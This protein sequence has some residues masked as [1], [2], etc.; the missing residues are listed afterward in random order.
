M[1]ALALAAGALDGPAPTATMGDIIDLISYYLAVDVASQSLLQEHESK[2]ARAA[3]GT[4]LAALI[5]NLHAAQ[6]AATACAVARI[7]RVQLLPSRSSLDELSKTWWIASRLDRD[8]DQLRRAAMSLGMQVPVFVRAAVALLAFAVSSEPMGCVILERAIDDP[9]RKKYDVDADVLKLAAYK[10]ATTRSDL[11]RWLDEVQMHFPEGV[12]QFVPTPLLTTP[13][14]ALEMP[15]LPQYLCPSI[16]HFVSAVRDRVRDAISQDG[17]MPANTSELYGGYLVEYIKAASSAAELEVYDIDDMEAGTERRADLLFVEGDRG[18]IVE[19][20]RSVATGG[21]SKHL[22]YPEGIAAVL[23]HLLGAFR[24]CQATL[25]RRPWQRRGMRLTRLAAIILVDEP[26]A[27]EGAVFSELLSAQTH[28]DLPFDVLSVTEFENAVAV[29]GVCGLV[30]LLI[31]KWAARL[32]GIPLQVFASKVR[33]LQTKKIPG[34][35]THLAFE[36]KELFF[37]IGL[38]RT[39]FSAEWP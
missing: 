6:V 13:L 18:L 2:L 32:Q 22:L 23:L 33:G 15:G 21:L 38:T 24:Q 4:D 3:I 7:F 39:E 10:L 9:F 29:L 28:V 14:L 1:A 8:A 19:V 27:A 34:K 20:K 26:V 12:R 17:S 5:P 35:R 31:D 37:E 25:W 30:E 16:H 36:D 11:Q